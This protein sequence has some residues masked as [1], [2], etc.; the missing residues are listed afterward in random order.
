MWWLQTAFTFVHGHYVD[1][2]TT[3]GIV[4]LKV[5]QT[6]PDKWPPLDKDPPGQAPTDRRPYDKRPLKQTP[7]APVWCRTDREN[8]QECRRSPL[9]VYIPL[10]CD[11]WAIV[12][13]TYKLYST[14]RHGTLDSSLKSLSCIRL[15]QMLYL[16]QELVAET[17]TALL[18]CVKQLLPA[19]SWKQHWRP[20]PF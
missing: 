9:D 4:W 2:S 12:Y 19:T 1:C 10:T 20:R 3:A 13:R 7:P 16:R 5:G 6:L 14:L 15:Y 18:R 8:F 17:N 11:V